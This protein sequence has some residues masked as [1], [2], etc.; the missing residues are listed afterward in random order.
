MEAT[1]N[2]W[3]RRLLL[4]PGLVEIF[5]RRGVEVVNQFLCLASSLVGKSTLRFSLATMLFSSLV[6]LLWA[7]TIICPNPLVVA[8]CPFWLAILLL[9]IKPAQRRGAQPGVPPP[10]Q[11]AEGE[12]GGK[13]NGKG[14]P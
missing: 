1:R 2:R 10:P 9:Q 14:G 5:L 7:S 11:Q 4:S 8:D 3:L 12:Q 6:V 13:Q